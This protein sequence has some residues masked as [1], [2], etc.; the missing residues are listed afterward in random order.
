[1]NVLASIRTFLK[2]CF[3]IGVCIFIPKDMNQKILLHKDC[4]KIAN[5]VTVERRAYNS[6]EV[7]Y[8]FQLG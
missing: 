7:G 1:M 5:Q 2:Q 3:S 6:A 4:M 8:D